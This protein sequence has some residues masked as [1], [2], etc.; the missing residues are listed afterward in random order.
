[1]PPDANARAHP[2][3]LM[4]TAPADAGPATRTRSLT[5]VL[6]R[7]RGDLAV[8]TSLSLY[9]LAVVVITAVGGRWPGLVAALTAPLLANWFL[10]P[11][12]HTFR[13][14]DGDN[15][16]ELVVFVSVASIVAG[17]VTVAEHRAHEA[18]RAWR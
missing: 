13:I 8:A 17:Y 3:P 7:Y 12:Y 15:L 9:L 6:V 16:L 11:P 2:L 4:S 18:R 1:M 5:A 14:S 10:I